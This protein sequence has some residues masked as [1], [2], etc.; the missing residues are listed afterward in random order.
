VWRKDCGGGETKASNVR[1]NATGFE[2]EN[3]RSVD[4]HAVGGEIPMSREFSTRKRLG[5]GAFSGSATE[6]EKISDVDLD[7]RIGREK[8]EVVLVPAKKMKLSEVNVGNV[9]RN[10]IRLSVVEEEDEIIASTG[11]SQ[12]GRVEGVKVSNLVRN[13]SGFES[14]EVILGLENQ[15]E[16]NG[17]RVEKDKDERL[18]WMWVL[19][20]RARLRGAGDLV[21]KCRY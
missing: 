10:G 20:W 2:T 15:G 7:V 5:K 9:R 3:V 21:E 1:R 16:D 12:R 14:L 11:K 19:G 6:M 8:E 13:G 18:A 4:E 17:G